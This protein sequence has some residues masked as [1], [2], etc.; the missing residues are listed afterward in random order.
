M[1]SPVYYGKPQ[2]NK[3]P[4]TPPPSEK[5]D[6]ALIHIGYM[7]GRE[8]PHE[9]GCFLQNAYARTRK[10]EPEVLTKE[11]MIQFVKKAQQ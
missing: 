5:F 3:E 4:M 7:K 9:R 6:S 8:D 2:I 1:R 10:R 11:R